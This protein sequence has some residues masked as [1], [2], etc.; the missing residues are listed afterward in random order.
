MTDFFFW[1]KV[2]NSRNTFKSELTQIFLPL[3]QLQHCLPVH[4]LLSG[5]HSQSPEGPGH[6][7]PSPAAHRLPGRPAPSG[8]PATLFCRAKGCSQEPFRQGEAN[9]EP[10]THYAFH[11]SL[12]TIFLQPIR[13]H[14]VQKG[15]EILS[16]LILWLKKN[17]NLLMRKRPIQHSPHAINKNA[18]SRG[19]HEL[20]QKMPK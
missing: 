8:C 18:S 17:E 1:F 4:L 6:H 10:T 7:E 3:L 19:T 13:W 5:A 16:E 11:P 9:P 20:S 15:N 14:L 12:F 2:S